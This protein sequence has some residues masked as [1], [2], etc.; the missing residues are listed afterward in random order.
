[1]TVTSPTASDNWSLQSMEFNCVSDTAVTVETIGFDTVMSEI[2]SE[3]TSTT[4]TNNV[5]RDEHECYYCDA[6]Y[7]MTFSALLAIMFI[8]K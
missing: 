6:A 7:S 4:I 3:I 5:N 1:M 2:N 8:V